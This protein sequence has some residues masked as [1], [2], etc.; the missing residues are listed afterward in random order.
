MEEEE[1]LLS[2]TESTTSKL[3]LP[4]KKK[5]PWMLL[6]VLIF[7][8]ITFIDVGAFLA[9]PPQTRIFEA[10]LC[11]TYYREEDPS[12]ILDDGSIPEKLCKVDIV[13][14]R[15]ASIFGWQEMFNA[16]PGILLAVPYG[17]LSDRIGRKWILAAN[18]VG[19]ELSFAWV[20]LIC[21]YLQASLKTTVLIATGYFKTLPL[22]LTWFSS[23]F[24]VIGGGPLVAMA[25]GISMIADIVPPEKRTTVFLYLVACV[26]V[27][28]IIA[29]IIAAQL[30]EKGDWLPL[31]L[32][33]A[34]MGVGVIIGAFFPETL[35]LRD[36]SEPKDSHDQDVE[37]EPISKH[38]SWTA[39]YHNFQSVVDFLMS[40]WTLA[41][42][43]F[44][45][46]INRLGRQ[47]MS[48]LIRYAS[49][50]YGWEI[51]D[52]AYLSSLR[53]ATNLVAV[54]AFI[55]LANYI[56]LKRFQFP[57]HRAD[58]WL[59]RV[60]IVLTSLAFF[61]M[62]IAAY[63][64]L[65]I[66]GLVIYNMGTGYTVAMRSLSIHVVG[67]Q[68]SPNI[69]TLMSTIALAEGIGAMIAGPL[70]NELFQVGIGLGDA[71]LGLPFL[72]SLVILAFMTVVTFRLNVNDKEASYVEVNGDEDVLDDETQRVSTALDEEIPR[73]RHAP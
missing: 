68:S 42:V 41:T 50:R 30:M 33:L 32:A 64:A 36:L 28:D 17:A 38:F 69:G 19:L 16:L 24:F 67:G 6:V 26:S 22:Q 23:A 5:K 7:A 37:L 2:P 3:L 47:A 35:H 11:L 20:L 73:H 70:L 58:L 65:L 25:I 66:L 55:P 48:L 43:V 31:L 4:P 45:F 13:Q 63:P 40:D 8:M 29:P 60:S 12:V 21:E 56:L 14:Q 54:T 39:Q 49:K 44:T 18:L 53:A 51:K 52:A 61:V 9:E 46:L 72:A 62:G 27:A 34:I 59:A 71:W 1:T 57:A 15:L 10:N